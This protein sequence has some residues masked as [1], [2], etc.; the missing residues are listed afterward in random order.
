MS[1]I[2]NVAYAKMLDENAT[3]KEQVSGLIA[4]RESLVVLNA[5]LAEKNE[6]LAAKLQKLVDTGK[7]LQASVLATLHAASISACVHLNEDEEWGEDEEWDEDEDEGV[8]VGGG[9]ASCVCMGARS[10]TVAPMALASVSAVAGCLGL[11][12]FQ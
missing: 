9:V 2:D 3:L 12:S 11:K 8:C 4:A 1:W 6:I 10:A 5:S 7:E